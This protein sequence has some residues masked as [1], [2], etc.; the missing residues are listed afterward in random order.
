MLDRRSG[1]SQVCT[2]AIYCLQ[3]LTDIFYQPSRVQCLI[4]LQECAS[5]AAERISGKD[6]SKWCEY[7]LLQYEQS[8]NTLLLLL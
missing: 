1:P 5:A 3:L 2:G 6:A 4:H 7:I 8:L